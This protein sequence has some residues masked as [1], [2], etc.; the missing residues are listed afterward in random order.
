M[1]LGLQGKRALVTGGSRGIG[2]ATART[3]ASEGARLVLAAR[4][5]KGL[6]HAA[7]AIE[8]ATG[9]RVETHLS[10]LSASGAAAALAEAVGDVDVLVNN[11]GAI[12]AGDIDSVDESLWREAWNL[13]VFG[14]INLCRSYFSRMRLTGGVIVNVIG[15][16]GERHDPAYIAGVT[17]NAGLM[18]MTRALGAAG[19]ARGIRVVGVNPGLTRTDRLERQARR[20]AEAAGRAPDRWQEDLPALPFERPAEPEEVAD[21][22]AFLA[23]ARASYVSGTILTVDGGHSVAR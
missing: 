19:P 10:D 1:D 14:Y 18:A 4:D 7:S 16:G 8:A 23:S 17:A 13:K 15:T 20:R 22:V 12:P 11:A 6:A 5:P 2:L 21:A 3:L 9:A